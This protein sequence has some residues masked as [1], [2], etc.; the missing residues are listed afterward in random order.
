LLKKLKKNG[1]KLK[2]LPVV[3]SGVDPDRRERM[4]KPWLLELA[5]SFVKVDGVSFGDVGGE[6]HQGGSCREREKEKEIRR[7]RKDKG[8]GCL[9]ILFFFLSSPHPTFCFIKKKKT[10]RV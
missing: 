10:I 3:A 9:F 6:S 2:P 5:F 8:G 1:R 4:R 7:R